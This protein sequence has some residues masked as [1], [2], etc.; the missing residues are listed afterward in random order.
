M[1][2]AGRQTKFVFIVED[3]GDLPRLLNGYPALGDEK[4][5]RQDQVQGF[6]IPCSSSTG[7]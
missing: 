4:C 5:E 3:V 2:L 7:F 6:W 1:L